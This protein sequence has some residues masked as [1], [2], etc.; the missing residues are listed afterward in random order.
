MSVNGNKIRWGIIGAGGIAKAFAKGVQHSKTG[1]MLAVGS[2]SQ[3]KAD[4]FAK[5]LNVPRKYGS[6][7]ALLAD[8][9]VQA[10]YIATPHPMHAE[11]AIR[12]AEAGKHILCEK[13]AA[14]NHFELMAMIEAAK[15]NNVFFMEA[16][17][18]RCHPQTKKL[19]ELLREKVIGEVRVI[20]ATFSFHAGFNPEG[21]LFKN[22]LGGGGILDVGCYCTSMCRLVAGVAL[23]KDFAEPLSLKGFGHLGASNADEWAVASAKFDKGI[24]ANL[25]TGVAV[26][27]E[28]VVRIFGSEGYILI[29]SPWIPARE[30]GTTEIIVKRNDE[31]EPR[32]I[33]IQT[34][35]W[36]Y[37]IEAD[38][39]AEH[40]ANKEAKFPAMSYA[41]SMGNMRMLDMWRR[42][43]ELVYEA[44][45]PEFF[46]TPV[47][48]RPL[49]VK[50]DSK[51]KY[52]T[53]AGL[54]KQVSR[55]IMGVDN[56]TTFPHAA[57]MFDDFFER[58]GNCF[59]SA[60]IYG[61]GLCEKTLG[62]WVKSRNIRD[63]VV[64]LDKGAHTPFCDPDNLTRELKES[65]ER[66]QMDHLDIYMMHRDNPDIPVG[67][68]IDV[69]NEH[70][71]AGRIKAFGGSNWSIARV[72]K[73]NAYAKRK[74]LAGFS[75]V[76]NNFSL[77]R[78]VNPVWAGCIAA[79]DPE[80]RKWFKKNQ[81]PLM[82]W[83]SQARGFF[84]PERARPDL[85]SDESL[86]FS[87]YSDDNFQRQARAFELAK[88]KNVRPISI[89]LAY[90]LCQPFPT[91]PLIGPRAISET[92]SSF[93][94]LTVELTPKEL[95]WLNL[96]I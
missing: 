85:T 53:V 87:W 83:S 11:W 78:M 65:L 28:N 74:G 19:V 40:L 13:P 27:Q 56:Q 84:V 22:Q 3:E 63:K 23:G 25:A 34:G 6:Y 64:I 38:T 62:N 42:E 88:K 48:K 33:Q 15:D 30:G 18:Y 39:V 92:K 77:A 76:S 90:V 51:M 59:D 35:E 50:A 9:D 45:K 29:P 46:T 43:L 31:K 71:K 36:L 93:E 49:A 17:M 58:G 37:G 72:K 91:F 21:R 14:L 81:M 96:E 80:S 82:G 41:D 4:A 57:V 44:E 66:L 70:V 10:V 69:L 5:E 47:H 73:A 75:A 24:V 60:H 16:F 94:A 61:G 8:K 89:A 26:N 2:R 79:S 1:E 54:E 86:V 12:A 95:K 7:E 32:K 68:F 52:G 55:L 20:Q 67:E